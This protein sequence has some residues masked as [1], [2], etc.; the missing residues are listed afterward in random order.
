M[1]IAEVAVK[2]GFTHTVLLEVSE[3]EQ[4][5][6][7]F[8]HVDLC[9][10]E[11]GKSESP[12]VRKNIYSVGVTLSVFTD[13]PTFRLFCS[14]TFYRVGNRCFDRLETNGRQCNNYRRY[15]RKEK[16]VPTDR[17]P[18]TI[19][20]QPVIHRIPGNRHSNNK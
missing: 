18:V 7:I 6:Y 9:V 13:F 1:P 17:Y 10:Q 19:I 8:V 14:Q 4:Y 3:N 12:K 2:Q 11:V 15:S 20:D 5:T 16:Y